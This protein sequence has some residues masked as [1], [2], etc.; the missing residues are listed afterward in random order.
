MN[1]VELVAQLQAHY[2]AAANVSTLYFNGS[3]TQ[4]MQDVSQLD[5]LV[6][7]HGAGKWD[8]SAQPLVPEVCAVGLA[9][10]T[11]ARGRQRRQA[12]CTF[13]HAVQGQAAWQPEQGACCRPG[14]LQGRSKWSPAAAETGLA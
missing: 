1:E 9:S 14:A 6:G 12:A 10:C 11:G 3:L 13:V 7:V 8:L 4:A 5:V 2:G